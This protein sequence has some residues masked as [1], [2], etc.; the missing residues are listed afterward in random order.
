ME[1][2]GKEQYSRHVSDVLVRREE[3]IHST[4]KRNNLSLFKRPHASTPSRKAAQFQ[5]MKS[6]CNLFRQLFIAA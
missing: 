1:Q 5:E 3:S 6:D 2:L 4:V